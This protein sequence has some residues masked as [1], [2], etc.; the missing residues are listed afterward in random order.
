MTLGELRTR[1]ARTVGLSTSD[2]GDLAL[3]DGWVNEAV[4]AFLR[5]T[6]VNV[7]TAALATTEGVEDYTLDDDILSFQDVWYEPSSGGQQ[8][9]LEPVSA[10][11][12]QGMRLLGSG[13]GLTPR[14]YALQGAHLLKLYPTPGSSSDLVHITYTPRPGLISDS[15]H[16]PSDESRGNIPPEYHSIVEAYAKWKAASAEEHRPSEYGLTFQAEWERG[17][18]QVRADINRKAGVFKAPKQ[19]RRRSVYPLTPGTDIR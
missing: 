2:A 1:I 6:K 14:Y 16:Q 5:D 15:A 7:V 19:P 11:D 4:L 13:D 18:G 17:I 3:I 8:T 9:M 12:I 10:R